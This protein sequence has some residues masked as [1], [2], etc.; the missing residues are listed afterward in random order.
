M[1][2][3]DGCGVGWGQANRAKGGRVG[4]WRVGR[5]GT[6]VLK[7]GK[8]ICTCQETTSGKSGHG[9]VT[10]ALVLA[11]ERAHPRDEEEHTSEGKQVDQ[12]RLNQ[13][14]PVNATAM[15]SVCNRFPERFK[16][17]REGR[18]R[19]CGAGVLA[20]QKRSQR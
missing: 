17:S 13:H 10:Q 8:A 18:G 2:G 3:V 4:C 1:R 14:G 19:K 9:G 20:K 11:D 6:E 16:G 15:Q 5:S 12:A 7:R